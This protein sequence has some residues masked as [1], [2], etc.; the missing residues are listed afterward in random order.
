MAALVLAALPG[1]SHPR[2]LTLVSLE[3]SDLLFKMSQTGPL[4]NKKKLHHTVCI[5]QSRSTK[6]LDHL[7]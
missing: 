7:A 2:V 1:F 3:L 4:I 6:R 5:S